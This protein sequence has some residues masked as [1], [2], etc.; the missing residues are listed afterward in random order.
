MSTAQSASQLCI[1]R[2]Q[3]SE[4]PTSRRSRSARAA[5]RGASS[6]RARSKSGTPRACAEKG[7]LRGRG[8]GEAAI[9]GG[10]LGGGERGARAAN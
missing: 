1:E 6:S 7:A 9:A 8:D 3:K 5:A 4:E 2:N 10:R